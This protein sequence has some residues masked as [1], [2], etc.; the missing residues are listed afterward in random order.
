[1]HTRL[2]TALAFNAQGVVF[3][4]ESPNVHTGKA[5][6]AK[7]SRNT[8]C[9]LTVPLT[10]RIRAQHATSKCDNQVHQNQQDS[11]MM[12]LERAFALK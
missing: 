11:M 7:G 1:M 9:T 3:K 4:Q 10:H 5:L 2:H 12:R 8:P 6:Y